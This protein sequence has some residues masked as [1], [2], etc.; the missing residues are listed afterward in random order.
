ME[1]KQLDDL[2][3]SF[4]GEEFVDDDDV[5]I[6]K[7][8]SKANMNSKKDGF[9][10][11]KSVKKV[12]LEPKNVKSSF[13][14][15]S[16]SSENVKE[17]KKTDDGYIQIQPNKESAKQ[18]IHVK[19]NKTVET[20]PSVNPWA[21]DEEKSVGFFKEVST[22]KAI[23]GIVVILLLFSIFTQ[24]FRFTASGSAVSLSSPEAEQKAVSFVNA[25]LLR[26]PFVAEAKESIDEGNVYKVTLIVGQDKIDSYI[27]KDGKIFF[28]QG[29]YTDVPLQNQLALDKNNSTG[30]TS[31]N[32]EV[33]ESSSDNSN[34]A[35][36]STT[37]ANKEITITAKKWIFE[38]FR[39]KAIQGE[40]V[41]LTINPEGAGL[42]FSVSPF[43]VSQKVEGKTVV[44]FTADKKGRFTIFCDDCDGKSGIVLGE[45]MVE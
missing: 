28:P 11:S 5:K 37:T 12:K 24:G 4:F 8:D 18:N 33:S 10:E 2:D 45:L 36:T 16:K 29:F 30:S 44:E 3:E 20:R 13:K 32:V 7:E 34:E 40:K 39:I 31:S 38:P 35:E 25:N 22:W 15:S 6:I 19:E 42:T 14:Q 41:K 27:S 9:K 21:D 26:A 43:I 23:T 1:Q 17:N